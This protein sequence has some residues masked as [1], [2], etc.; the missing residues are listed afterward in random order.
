MLV[1]VKSSCI[2]CNL[3]FLKETNA[4]SKKKHL[5]L[6]VIVPDCKNAHSAHWF[7]SRKNTR[8]INRGGW[9][10]LPS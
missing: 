4:S 5:R 7:P 6:V 1:T 8:T 3:L 10:V 9:S 2:F